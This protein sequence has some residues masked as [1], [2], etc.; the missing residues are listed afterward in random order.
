MRRAGSHLFPL[1]SIL[2]LF[3]A[4]SYGQAWSGIISNQRATNWAYAGLPGDVPPSGSWTQ[5]GSTIKACGASGAAVSPA[6]CGVT[7]ALSS[8]GANHYVL[9]G[10]GD[11][12][13]NATINVP[14]NCVLRGAG[15]NATKLHF[16]NGGSYACSGVP[17]LI[18]LGN[19]NF[20]AGYCKIGTYWP[21]PSPNWSNNASGTASWTGSYSQGSMSITLDNVAGIVPNL[22][23]ITVDQCDVG[24]IGAGGAYCS[25]TAGAV[26]SAN[27]AFGGLGYAVNDTF[28]IGCS[29]NFGACYGAVPA[30]TG[31]VTS[32]A[33]GVVTG[34]TITSGGGG[35]TY[36]SSSAASFGGQ[37]S[38]STTTTSGGGSGLSLVITG[39]SSYDNKS[40]LPCAITMICTYEA[41]SNNSRPARSEQE[42]FVATSIS[43]SGPY[44][45]TLNRPISN[46][47][48]ASGRG[49]QAF[50]GNGTVTN[51]GLE[52]VLVD[53]SAI[54]SGSCSN[55]GCITSVVVNNA[56]KVWIRG[57]ASNYS[58]VFHVNATYAVNMLIS[59]SYFYWTPNAG[60]TSYGIG[61]ATAVSDA[62]FE[63]NILQGIVDP[64]NFNATCTGCVVAYNFAVNQYDNATNVLFASNP[65]HSA[66]TNYILTEGNIGSNVQQD[67][68]HG[69]HFMDTYFRNFFN[70]YQANLGLMPNN[71][72]VPIIV[73]AFS[74]YN[75]YLGNVLGTP[76][77]HTTYQCIPTST[78]QQ[79]CPAYGG[80]GAG[81]LHIWDLGWSAVAQRDFTNSPFTPNDPL[82]ASSL[83]RYGN[84]DV[85]NGS[86]QWNSP[87]VPTGDPNFPNPVPASHT[88][89][90][91][92]Y[93]GVTDAHANC[94]TGLSFWKNPVT[95]TCPAYPPIGPDVT[96]G[97]MG[98][99]TSGPYKWSRV[100][101]SA[102]CAGG[103]FTASVNDGFVNSI[104]AMRCFLNQM[105]GRPDGTGSI[106]SFNRA[107]CYASDGSGGT[108]PPGNPPPTNP[109]PAPTGLAATVS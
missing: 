48:W 77:F 38:V 35:Y 67:E 65:M 109:P 25:A 22:T 44:T 70:G 88:F 62:L 16:V 11:F 105:S 24:F 98:M 59:D 86:V 80:F 81:Y 4:L 79:Y 32:V 89:P 92:F 12:Y 7:A 103:S 53:G 82:T 76:G 58:N 61:S 71:N 43:G 28:T 83:Y 47:D 91:S 26:T 42:V 3:S 27:I 8:C 1:I 9:L 60:T 41:A 2:L 106:L 45:V 75:N 84:Y 78:T 63:N 33:A 23:P 108:T 39:V 36:S 37:S 72:S 66:A 10:S 64:V 14:S 52:D 20:Y 56:Y 34:F 21:C 40:L 6:S 96:S 57:I 104:P 94:G 69:P 55:P 68:T 74:R 18:C 51:L 101:D 73:N 50:W 29:K 95:G 97:D 102:Q 30:A 31:K 90:S 85:V 107:S 87:E 17:G 100:L 93:N 19:S 13:L 5:S 46:P 15:A 49:P 99:C 54:T